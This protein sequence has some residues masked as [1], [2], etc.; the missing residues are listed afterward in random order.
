MLDSLIESRRA[1]AYRSALGGGA[2]SFLIHSTLI[3]GAVYATLHASVALPPLRIVAEIRLTEMPRAPAT[4]ETNL[5]VLVPLLGPVRLLVS[6][7]IPPV[8]PPPSTVPFDPTR[9]SGVGPDSGVLGPNHPGPAVS[10][11]AVYAST[12]WRGAARPDPDR[13]PGHDAAAAIGVWRRVPPSRH[14][15]CRRMSTWRSA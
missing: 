5:G 3:A 4:A 15:W 1:T 14:N 8:I 12:G 7:V 6:A 10:P 2:A 13:A 9:Y 11:T